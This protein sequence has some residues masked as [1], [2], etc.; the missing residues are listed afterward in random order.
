VRSQWGV[1]PDRASRRATC[2]KSIQ[3]VG[4]R[5]GFTG[6]PALRRPTSVPRSRALSPS[7]VARRE[8]R[9]DRAHRPE[10][11]AV[12]RRVRERRDLTAPHPPP[13][14]RAA[15]EAATRAADGAR[16]TA[17]GAT[18]RRARR[19]HGLAIRRPRPRARPTAPQRRAV[20][21]RDRAP[22]KE[23][24]A[25][26]ALPGRVRGSGT[27]RRV[28]SYPSSQGATR[29]GHRAPS[30]VIPELPGRVA[31][32]RACGAVGGEPIVQSV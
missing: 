6:V 24:R 20:R 1:R 12:V 15:G 30:I 14:A 13:R 9:A 23:L 22:F 5:C 2:E 27:G 10:A 7:A 8:C 28:P 18:R 31:V 29:S 21:R 26:G 25:R 17:P 19:G 32:R 3:P 11:A 16:P 4:A